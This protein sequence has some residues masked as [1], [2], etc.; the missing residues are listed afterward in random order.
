MGGRAL[1]DCT[2]AAI[3]YLDMDGLLLHPIL[4]SAFWRTSMLEAAAYQARLTSTGRPKLRHDRLPGLVAK[5]KCYI[6]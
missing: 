4:P 1:T 3:D 6:G 5:P 2:V